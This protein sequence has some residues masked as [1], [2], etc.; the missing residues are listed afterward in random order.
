MMQLKTIRTIVYPVDDIEASTA[1]WS[2]IMGKPV[3]KNKDFTTFVG[4]DGIDIRLSRIQWANQP[5]TF[6]EV[7]DIEAAG[8][9]I[10]ELGATPM[11]EDEQGSLKEITT[12]SEATTAII[13]K[14]GRKL[15]IFKLVDGNFI[16]LLQ[17]L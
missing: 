16:G 8:R 12:E 3:Y 15:A 7:E 13:N 5:I 17:D 9:E 11:H 14:P 10:I 2:K 4:E 1:A 6:W